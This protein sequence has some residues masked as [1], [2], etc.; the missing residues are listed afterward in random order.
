MPSTAALSPAAI[1]LMSDGGNNTGAEPA[2]AAAVAR[3][4]KVTVYT[5]GLG[6][7]MDATVNSDG[8]RTADVDALDEDLLKQIA[9]TTHGTYHRASTEHD[10]SRVWSHLG[11]MVAWKTRPVEVGGLISGASAALFGGTMLLSLLWRRLD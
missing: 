8:D 6:R 10:L 2:D 1:V 3:R 9:F 4:L 11:R 5:V 7:P